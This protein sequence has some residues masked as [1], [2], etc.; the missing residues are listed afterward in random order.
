MVP[1][2]HPSLFPGSPLL[3]M[4]VSLLQSMLLVLFLSREPAIMYVS[5]II[6]IIIIHLINNFTLQLQFYKYE[7]GEGL[8][9]VHEYSSEYLLTDV[10]GIEDYSE[11]ILI[12][13][14]HRNT[15][16]FLLLS[17]IFIYFGY[18]LL[19]V[20]FL[21]SFPLSFSHPFL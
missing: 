1:M 2:A 13:S 11:N 9:K 19:F 5:F 21:S 7:E 18:F 15:Y 12:G 4:R 20:V 14:R 8:K 3:M 17:F 10:L 16:C 6:I